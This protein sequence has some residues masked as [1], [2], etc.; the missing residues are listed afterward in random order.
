MLPP[1]EEEYAS[2]RLLLVNCRWHLLICVSTLHL[3]SIH[4]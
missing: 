3:E 1:P 4:A 2:F